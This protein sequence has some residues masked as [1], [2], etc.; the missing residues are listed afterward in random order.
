MNA[1]TI[2]FILF[3]AGGAWIYGWWGAIGGA[4]AGFVLNMLLGTLVTKT[5]GGLMP[6]SVRR[7]LAKNLLR[8]HQAVA[9]AAFPGLPDAA[10]LGRI[11][12]AVE[13]VCRDA[14]VTL[15]PGTDIFTWQ[16]IGDALARC[17]PS[18]RQPIWRAST[19][20]WLSKWRRI[21]GRAPRVEPL[22]EREKQRHSPARGERRHL[23]RS[24]EG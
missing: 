17:T 23:T 7:S 8:N 11:E 15:P 10:L 21:G 24:S 1:P 5:R 6:R 4:V 3:V 16:H 18:R 14:A 12:E 19:K 2:L 20:A 13:A 9:Q 22:T